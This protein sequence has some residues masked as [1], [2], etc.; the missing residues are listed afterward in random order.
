MKKEGEGGQIGEMMTQ[1]IGMK[2]CELHEQIKPETNRK[3]KKKKK[4]RKKGK[5]NNNNK[6]KK[7]KPKTEIK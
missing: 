6:I 1:K 3:K 2:K 4:K 7:K 5:N